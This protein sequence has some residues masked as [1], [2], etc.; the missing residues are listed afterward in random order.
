M[1]GRPWRAARALPASAVRTEI[2]ARTA[3]VAVWDWIQSET[4]AERPVRPPARPAVV[5]ASLVAA[6]YQYQAR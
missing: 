6:G 3:S 1:C 2:A 5:G 4:M